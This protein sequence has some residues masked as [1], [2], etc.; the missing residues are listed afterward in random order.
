M[1]TEISAA[2]E[3]AIDRSQLEAFVDP[4]KGGDV[5][6]AA[7]LGCG[8]G[9]VAAFMAAR[10]LD[11]VGVDVSEAMVTLARE[12]H[13][14]IVFDVGRL[15]SLPIES[16][17]LGGAV[18]WY[19]IIYTPPERLAE[20]VAELARVVTP[21]GHVL[22]GFQAGHGEAVHREEAHGTRLTL[23]RYL[24]AVSEVGRRLEEGGF[25]V[26]ETTQ[27]EQELDHETDPQGFVLAHRI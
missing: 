12:A 13:R 15:D 11:V 10:G 16:G 22:L 1:G 4:V 17:E 25:G 18:C 8:P 24:H 19:S 2:T 7:D 26:S 27:R 14:D 21:G 3:S 20:V 5:W 9:R 6:R 23:T